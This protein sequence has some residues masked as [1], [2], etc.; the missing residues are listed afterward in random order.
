MNTKTAAET[1]A[2]TQRTIQTWCRRGAI[3]ATKTSGHWNIDETSLR[4]RITLTRPRAATGEIRTDNSGR[5]LALGNAANLERAFRTNLPVRI[6]TG[7]CAGDTVHLGLHGTTYGDYGVTPETLGLLRTFSNGTA[8]YAIDIHKLDAA[9]RL[10]AIQDAA[11]AE[12]DRREIEAAAAD[13]AYL[14]PTYE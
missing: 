3:A 8:A 1:A 10:A 5:Y 6:T 14:H 2:V 4:H 13:H 7:P 9:P 12:A 11:E